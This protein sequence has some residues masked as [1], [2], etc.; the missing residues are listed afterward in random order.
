MFFLTSFDKKKAI[1][2]HPDIEENNIGIEI[3]TSFDICRPITM[4]N[5]D[6]NGTRILI[7]IDLYFSSLNDCVALA[8]IIIV[9]EKGNAQ[10][11]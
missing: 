5:S 7:T 3:A 6:I 8:I 4:D 10:A 2:T 1:N 9:T 11:L